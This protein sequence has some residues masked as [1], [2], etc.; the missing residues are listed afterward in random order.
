MC[1]PGEGPYRY[2]RIAQNGK[3]ASGMTNYLSLSGFE[4]Y[5]TVIDA[6]EKPLAPLDASSTTP[7]KEKNLL[8][9]SLSAVKKT[10]KKSGGKNATG[11][12]TGPSKALPVPGLHHNR[13]PNAASLKAAKKLQ[14]TPDKLN[15]FGQ[16]LPGTSPASAMAAEFDLY[17][18]LPGKWQY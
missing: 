4:I 16:N 2:I 6:I 7:V 10:I 1:E 15:P 17:T 13:P 9:S 12:A 3:N 18:Q 11:S 8:S 5:G 14:Q